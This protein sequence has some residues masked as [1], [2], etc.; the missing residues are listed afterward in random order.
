MLIKN[1][2]NEAPNFSDGRTPKPTI[3]RDPADEVPSLLEL[4]ADSNTATA[5]KTDQQDGNKRS[6]SDSED[7]QNGKGDLLLSLSLSLSH[8]NP[9]ITLYFMDSCVD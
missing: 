1:K 7:K 8:T 5:S 4:Q 3:I 2:D 6:T 9:H